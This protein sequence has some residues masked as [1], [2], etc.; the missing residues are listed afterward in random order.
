MPLFFNIKEARDYLIAN[1]M[2]YTL[3]K[4]R[5]TGNASIMIGSRYRGSVKKIGNGYVSFVEQIVNDKQLGK[6]VKQ[7]GFKSIEKWREKAKD[8][9][10]L[11]IEIG[12]GFNTP[13]VV[14]W[15]MEQIVYNY[16]NSHLIRVNLQCPQVPK[17]ITERSI[18]CNNATKSLSKSIHNI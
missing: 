2:V 3:R 6:Y 1:K 16:Q 15:P 11:I 14:R 13:G 17:E 4:P 18:T 10:L 9:K 8:C 12:A 5:K 7:S